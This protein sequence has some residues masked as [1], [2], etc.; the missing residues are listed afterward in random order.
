[1][2]GADLRESVD[3]RRLVDAA[4]RLAAAGLSPGA[5]G[6]LSVRTAD[7]VLVTRGGAALARLETRDL[8]LIRPDGAIEGGT[9]TKEAGMHTALYARRTDATAVVHLHSPWATAV[10]CLPGR[11]GSAALEPYTPYHPMRLGRVPLV[12][13]A[14]PGS[15]ALAEAVGAAAT[16]DAVLLLAHHGSVVAAA[17]LD[18]AVDL[19][20]ELEV[21]AQ[22]TIVLAGTAARPLPAA[23]P[24]PGARGSGASGSRGSGSGALRPAP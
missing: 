15:A 23:S 6:N 18:T 9:P 19:A 17:D 11:D 5:S 24:P 20:E 10:S 21:A 14:A 4:R 8:V 7:G 22:L 2:T 16:A 13:D 12:P 3:A 1:V